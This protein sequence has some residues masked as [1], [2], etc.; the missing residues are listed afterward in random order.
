MGF[1]FIMSRKSLLVKLHS[2]F[3]N[4][5]KMNYHYRHSLVAK[6]LW[7]KWVRRIAFTWLFGTL[8]SDKCAGSAFYKVEECLHSLGYKNDE[9]ERVL[10]ADWIW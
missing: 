6:H 4:R 7:Y 1:S 10:L 3:D 2:F 9:R 5:N 8:F